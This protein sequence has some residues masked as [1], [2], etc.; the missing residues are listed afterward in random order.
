M[1]EREIE[2]LIKALAAKNALQYGKAQVNSVMSA[3]M[4]ERPDLR[5]RAREIVQLVKNVVEYI[6]SL[7]PDKLREV[8]KGELEEA[9]RQERQVKQLPPLPNAKEG[10]VVTRFAPNPDFVIHIGNARPAILSYEYA[11]MYRGKMI[12]R[13]EDTDPRTKT[14]MK[15]AYEM[16]KEDLRW[17]GVKWDEEYIQSLR[18]EHFYDVMREALKRGCA[19]VDLGG[20]ESKA[21]IS[22]GIEP[23]YRSKEP[24]WQLEQFDR[25]LANYYKEGEAVIRFKTDVRH[26]NP[27]IRDWVAMRIID[28]S[29][30][31]HPLVGDKYVVWPTYNFAVSVDDYS[32]GIT[33]VLRGKEHQVNTEKQ[34][35]VYRCFGWEEPTFIH[36][37]RLKLEGFIMSKSYI[38]KIMGEN[39]GEFMGLDDPRFGTIAGLRRRG[40]LPEA[41]RDVILDV[42]VKP[43]DAKLSWKNL[44][45]ANRKRVDPIADRLMFVETSGGQ[46][47][48]MRLEQEDCITAS[49]P[50]HPN[51]PERTRS[52]TVCGGDEVYVPAADVK[53]KEVR[54]AELGNYEVDLESGKLVYMGSSVDEAR[55]KGLKIIQWVP[56]K[57][58]V[59][60]V[61]LEPRELKLVRHEG[62]VEGAVARYDKGARLQF[63]R[64]GFVIIDRKDPLTLIFTHE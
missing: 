61:V 25:M 50:F 22:K 28:T 4:A 57:D 18:M 60:A 37:G 1:S 63:I 14:P 36:F 31:P 54:L 62:Y 5:Q 51:T 15:E 47:L 21:L 17:L 23:P 49:I 3:L 2:D 55:A 56:A 44:A 11:R 38:K 13:F 32:M 26:P 10:A 8:Y 6:N 30:Y 33:H 12:L 64:F 42:G 52:I 46:G 43:G 40:V 41:I 20:D 59:S 24:E 53:A 45:A 7:P 35:Y 48:K 58:S 39:P 34:L 16:I 27:S 19:Y 29:K 9:R